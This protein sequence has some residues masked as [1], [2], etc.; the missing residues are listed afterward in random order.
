MKLVEIV[1]GSDTSQETTSILQVLTK[2]I[3]K[4]GVTVGNCDGFVGN[5][6]LN[7]YTSEAVL[8]LAEGVATIEAIDGALQGEFGMALGPLQMSDL[9]GNDIGYFIRKERKWT[10]DDET[11]EVGRNRPGRY[12]EL[13]DAMVTELGRIGHKAGKGW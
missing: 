11:K 3:G 13:G 12:T 7:P 2:R 1:V 9:A 10:R 6:M 5:R 8:L 4:I